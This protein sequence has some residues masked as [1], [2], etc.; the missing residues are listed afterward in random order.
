MPMLA[1]SSPNLFLMVPP[2]GGFFDPPWTA[3]LLRQFHGGGEIFALETF[4]STTGFEGF[5]RSQSGSSQIS[6]HLRNRFGPEK[7]SNQRDR[8]LLYRTEDAYVRTLHLTDHT[9]LPTSSYSQQQT[10]R[11][12]RELADYIKAHAGG[13]YESRS[14]LR[15]LLQPSCDGWQ[16]SFEQRL[17]KG[18]TSGSGLGRFLLPAG[19]KDSSGATDPKLVAEKTGQ[20]GFRCEIQVITICEAKSDVKRRAR[21]ALDHITA[22]VG[23]LAGGSKTWSRTSVLEISGRRLFGERRNRATMPFLDLLKFLSPERTAHYPLSPEE[24][25]PLWPTPLSTPTPV[26]PDAVLAP[27]AAPKSKRPAAAKEAV[28]A[29]P[30]VSAKPASSD[31]PII[32]D[33]SRTTGARP[34][35]PARPTKPERPWPVPERFSFHSAQPCGL[36]SLV[37]NRKNLR[38]KGRGRQQGRDSERLREVINAVRPAMVRALGLSERDILTMNQL[39]DLPIGSAQDLAYAYGRSPT[40]CYESLTHLERHGLALRRDVHIGSTLEKRYWI[41]DDQWARIM[42]DRIRSHPGSAID[43]LWL[44]PSMVAAVYRVAGV[45][46]QSA[47][48]RRLQ[49]LR[50]LRT[51][52]FDA[53][54]Q[55][56]DG[57]MVCIWAG[58][59]QSGEKLEQRL[60]RCVEEFNRWG[61]GRGT[62]WPGRL[63][64]IVP[65]P[66]QAERVWR[67]A[68]RCGLE[69]C[70]AVYDLSGQTLTG[71]LD[72]SSSRGRMPPAISDQLKPLRLKVDPLMNF[73]AGDRAN[74]MTRLLL[75]IEEHPGII[76]NHLELLT[77]INGA[78][79]AHTLSTL[80][81][82]RSIHK[83]SDGGYRLDERQLAAAA[84]RDRA[85]HALPKRRFGPEQLARYSERRWQRH[86]RIQRLLARFS[87]AGHAVAPGWE[88]VDRTFHPDGVVWL[89]KS[90]WGPGWHY[91]VDAV[92]ALQESTV[93]H[94][95]HN[96]CADSRTDRYPALVICRPEVEELFWKWGDGRP[97]LTSSV[98]RLRNGAGPLARGVWLRYGEPAEISGQH[99]APD[100]GDSRCQIP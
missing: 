67:A 78:A 58:I 9:L 37:L 10:V 73:L 20:V 2:E 4:F 34:V 53:L 75:A 24:I 8:A 13:A 36:P 29:A 18:T 40:T 85:W 56:S 55:C 94:V 97:M 3:D 72:L 95:L 11:S 33:E 46:V 7:N 79:V 98:R 31:D 15:V 43:R 30:G 19:A 16:T 26:S 57:W 38:P 81:E 48:G 71:D 89:D 90:P 83:L 47:P 76:A 59:W 39:A 21:S 45:L 23:D 17:S 32:R 68:R 51:H 27:G 42:G 63:V 96:V 61:G 5:V 60:G 66:W 77:G 91:I 54:V 65:H 28:H 82:R 86:R 52:P 70:C 69:R 87:A 64:F 99:A 14:M 41:P 44:N 35:T 80:L 84:R 12:W 25:A 1:T 22:L 74:L 88:A 49:A 93:Q 50:W 92:R 6:R 62:C 100:A